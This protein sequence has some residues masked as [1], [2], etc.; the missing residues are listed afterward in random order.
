M[1][2]H[3][4]P[5][6][7]M[8]T[9][10]PQAPAAKG[11]QLRRKCACGSYGSGGGSCDKC[12][13]DENKLQRAAAGPGKPEGLPQSVHEVLGS[14]G[15]PLDAATRSWMEPR[16]NYDFSGVRVHTDARA[17]RSARDVNALA[18]T[19][20][21]DVVFGAGQYAPGTERG[22]RLLA[23]ELTHVVQQTSSGAS[24][25]QAS[26]AVSEPGDAAEVEADAM[27]DRVMSGESADVTQAPNATL[28]ALSEGETAG[29]IV[30]AALGVGA[31]F[32]VLGLAGVFDRETYSPEELTAYLTV[33]AT[34]RRIENNRNS[35]NKARNVVRNWRENV[36]GFNINN[37]FSVR[38]GSLSEVE[39]KR[40]LIKE[41]LS[42]VT[43]GEDEE[44]ILTILE[45]SSPEAVLQILD[46]NHGISIQM[47]DGKIGGDNHR[48]FEAILER[49]FPSSSTARRDNAPSCTARQGLMIEYARR[50][51]LEMANNAID[52]ITKRRDDPNFRAA[53]EC[54]FQGAAVP[55]QRRI[56]DI[57]QN[58]ATALADRL[59]HCAPEGIGEL[60]AP[61][62]ITATTGE[63]LPP[64][65]CD[66][67][68]ANAFRTNQGRQ[69]REVYLCG[70][71]FR[72][73][74]EVQAITV[75]HESAHAAGMDDH[76]YQPGCG[77]DL[78]TALTNADSYAF[79]A[80]D[81]MQPLPGASGPDLRTSEPQMPAVSVGNFRNSGAVSPENQCPTCAQLPGLGLAPDQFRNIMELRGDITGHRSE[82][83]YDFK[84]TKEVAVWRHGDGGWNRL[85]YDAP[86]TPD[87]TFETDEHVTPTN[88]HIYSV[89]APGF[90]GNFAPRPDADTYSYKANFVESVNARVRPGPWMPVSNQFEW[91]SVTWIEKVNGSWERS[92][93]LNEI[94]PGHIFIGEGLPYGPG[95]YPLPNYED[96]VPV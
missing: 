25:Q 41:M 83:E 16:F 23:H 53:L 76:V 78:Q 56:L 58:T 26:K 90:P 66:L 20:G 43:A 61:P 95:D 17:A 88:N 79:F 48:R 24:A 27:A 77:I 54:R 71:F 65:R 75:L 10:A 19:V 8:P 42:G 59:Y 9:P 39:L 91:H 4:A 73:S 44:A 45:N 18:Y 34:T 40:L 30:G 60:E 57:F 81:L 92:Q 82:V 32:T 47:L 37:G 38:G 14:S 55:E 74:P 87:D 3:A 62:Q 86:G 96:G 63:L 52:V 31:I 2:E 22:T 89:D 72:K 69:F 85:G 70:A 15:Y 36:T 46:P 50:R 67:E 29:V 35:D 33:L 5:V 49:L 11:L 6:Q 84:R 28:H 93:G 64:V 7:A 80:N 13:R 51:A 12:S 21:R 68:D 94:E 1:S